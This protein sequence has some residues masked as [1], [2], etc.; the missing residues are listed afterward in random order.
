MPRSPSLRAH[1]LGCVDFDAALRM[2]RALV[3]HATEGAEPTLVLCEHPP[4]ITVGRH[5]SPAD[6]R[7]S[8]EDLL[9]R[10]WAVRWVPR[11][12]GCFLHLP[13]QLALYSVLSLECLGLDI[14]GY[15]D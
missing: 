10:R 12:G 3:F 15:I 1:L 11:G 7:L 9:A 6:I 8:T 14:P 2:Q 4:L 5:G 13:G